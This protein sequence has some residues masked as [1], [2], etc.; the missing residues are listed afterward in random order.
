MCVIICRDKM[1]SSIGTYTERKV[2]AKIKE[3][4]EKISLLNDYI[5]NP[6]FIIINGIMDI[7]SDQSHWK[8]HVIN[9]LVANNINQN[10]ILDI[11]NPNIDNNYPD[12]ITVQ[13]ISHC[14][15]EQVY[16]I[17]TNYLTNNEFDSVNIQMETL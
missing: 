11:I 13:F 5:K 4:R 10:W 14:V 3:L 9:I 6:P 2:Y 17:L 16:T 7:P 12:S 8:N 1:A 15:K